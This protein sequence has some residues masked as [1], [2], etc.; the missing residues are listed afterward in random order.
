M[1][2]ALIIW[3]GVIFVVLLIGLISLKDRPVAL[4]VMTSEQYGQWLYERDRFAEAAEWFT[5][6]ECKGAALYRAGEFKAAAGPLSGSST[7]EGFY[8]YGNALAMQGKYEEAVKAFQQALAL[9][10]DWQ[11]AAEN[12]EIAQASADRLEQVGGNMTDGELGADD[13]T[14]SQK[15][16]N[17][18]QG[19]D[20]TGSSSDVAST[21]AI[22]L[23][24]VQT[25]PADFLRSKFSYQAAM[26]E[27]Q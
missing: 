13:F 5:S 21:Q 20:E 2:R 15:K 19:F 8:N 9:K 24:Q 22:W 6:A 14:F 1:K 18:G 26:K 4:L 23:R 25:R 16:N 10:P 27:D 17:E 3:I 7:A 12:L 11:E